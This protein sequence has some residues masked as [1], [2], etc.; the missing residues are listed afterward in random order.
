MKYQV[1]REVL[2]TLI[3]EA[4][5]EAIACDLAADANYEWTCEVKSERIDE[6][7]D[8]DKPESLANRLRDLYNHHKRTVSTLEERTLAEAINLI[9]ILQRTILK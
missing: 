3:V 7:E 6:I 1:T 9:E 8:A 4:E 2:Q 5:D